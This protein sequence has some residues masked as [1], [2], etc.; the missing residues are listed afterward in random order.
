MLSV[1]GSSSPK[2]KVT[3]ARS[4]NGRSSR[5]ALSDMS[6]VRRHVMPGASKRTWLLPVCR[7]AECSP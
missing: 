3:G 7:G 6:V 2:M 5:S 1:T 4:T